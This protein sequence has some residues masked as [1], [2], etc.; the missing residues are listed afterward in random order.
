MTRGCVWGPDKWGKRRGEGK[1]TRPLFS[2]L[3]LNSAFQ[4]KTEKEK[5][6]KKKTSVYMTDQERSEQTGSVFWLNECGYKNTIWGLRERKKKKERKNSINTFTCILA[7]TIIWFVRTIYLKRRS[8]ITFNPEM[9][10]KLKSNTNKT[11]HFIS[12]LF[13]ICTSRN[14]SCL[15]GSTIDS[16]LPAASQVG[17]LCVC[18]LRI[19]RSFFQLR[20]KGRSFLLYPAVRRK[21]RDTGVMACMRLI[22]QLLGG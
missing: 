9:L 7:Q 20:S 17:S 13:R 11:L 2:E 15:T 19:M 22:T 3:F 12:F 4:I 8:I 6:R 14:P 18:K 21:V 16:R 1:K 5:K 10:T